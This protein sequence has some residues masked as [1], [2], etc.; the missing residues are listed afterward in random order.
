[1]VKNKKTR[2]KTAVIRTRGRLVL[3]ILGEGMRAIQG[4]TNK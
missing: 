1:M 2:K 4:K 3:N